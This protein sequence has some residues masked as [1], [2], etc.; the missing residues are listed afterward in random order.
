MHVSACAGRCWVPCPPRAPRSRSTYGRKP[1]PSPHDGSRVF[2]VFRFLVLLRM[3]ILTFRPPCS[4]RVPALPRGLGVPGFTAP[5]LTAPSRGADTRP[6]R[7]W[8]SA[9]LPVKRVSQE[10]K[11][12]PERGSEAA[13]G[14]MG[15]AK[16][17]SGVSGL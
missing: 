14:G 15:V 9:S 7:S 8:A 11:L 3:S 6:R 10:G 5:S 16:S 12:R 1:A 17:G 4:G 2:L 13:W